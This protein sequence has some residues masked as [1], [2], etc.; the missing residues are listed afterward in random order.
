MALLPEHSSAQLV[1]LTGN[2]CSAAELALYLEQFDYQENPHEAGHWTLVS[3]DPGHAD[4]SLRI[5]NDGETLTIYG[6][7]VDHF[8]RVNYLIQKAGWTECSLLS[9]DEDVEAKIAGRLVSVGI[10]SAST[11]AI[12]ASTLRTSAAPEPE[13]PATPPGP[14]SAL[15]RVAAS[16]NLSR[17][18]EN[19]EKHPAAASAPIAELHEEHE[20]IEILTIR[21]NALE[22]K[23]AELESEN[24]RLTRQLNDALAARPAHR[25]GAPEQASAST[26]GHVDAL[27]LLAAIEDHV[28]QSLDLS[29]IHGTQLVKDLQRLG[30]VFKVRLVPATA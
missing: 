1:M 11:D 19:S 17:L 26:A 22:E 3:N 21:N 9:R 28:S 27:A 7:A 20:R 13:V 6:E 16:P 15:P 4:C 29:A 25:I 12:P 14:E 24:S 10:T 2:L 30:Y 23:V 5:A 18:T 8:A